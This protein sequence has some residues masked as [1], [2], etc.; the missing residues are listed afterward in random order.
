[1]RITLLSR[2]MKPALL[3]LSSWLVLFGCGKAAAPAEPN[4][5]PAKT[6]DGKAT[7]KRSASAA[8]QRRWVLR[9]RSEFAAYADVSGLVRT[10]LFSNLLP[11]IWDSQELPLSAPQ[12]AC[13]RETL[14]HAREVAVGGNAGEQL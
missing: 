2:P 14:S 12:R 9:E 4:A 11:G 7:P 8:L 5:A 13:L 6:A 1:M 3:V 10:A